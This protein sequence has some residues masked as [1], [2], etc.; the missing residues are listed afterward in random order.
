MNLRTESDERN[1]RLIKERQEA[2]VIFQP[3]P[4][5]TFLCMTVFW[6]TISVADPSTVSS[7]A[8]LAAQL[9]FISVNQ[10]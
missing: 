5:G 1:K 4:S 6:A 3:P 10:N 9:C 2:K 7:S 8:C